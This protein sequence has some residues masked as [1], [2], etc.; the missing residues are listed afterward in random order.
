[1]AGFNF[2][3]RVDAEKFNRDLQAAIGEAYLKRTR[4]LIESIRKILQR[5]VPNQIRSLIERSSEYESLINGELQHELGVVDA[6]P[7]MDEIIRLLSE[8]LR[9]TTGQSNANQFASIKVLFTITNFALVLSNHLTTYTTING[10][11]IPW[12]DWL[13][14][15]GTYEFLSEHL[16]LHGPFAASR[17]GED[18]MV[19]SVTYGG[20]HVPE[21]FAGHAGVGEQP[22]NFIT[23]ALAPLEEFIRGIILEELH[24][25]GY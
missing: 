23:R 21:A 25:A 2:T 17:T 10:S 13:L 6:K 9:V 15:G 18:I 3:L 7:T 24:G 12:L 19:H 4:N 1:M 5:L 14:N 20:W 16:I 22:N 8:N 11:R